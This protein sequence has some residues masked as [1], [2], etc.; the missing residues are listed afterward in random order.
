MRRAVFLNVIGMHNLQRVSVAVQATS[1]PTLLAH[2]KQFLRG[3]RS[4]PEIGK[5]TDIAY[6]V[7]SQDTIRSALIA[8][9]AM[10]RG[11]KRHNDVFAFSA[12]IE[13]G[14]GPPCHKPIRE[15]ISHVFDAGQPEFLERLHHFWSDPFQGISLDEQGVESLGPHG[16]I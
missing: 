11:R 6:L 7:L 2:G 1:D 15:M 10:F 3:V 14:D 5:R 4:A 9:R 16:S 12:I 13:I 8:R